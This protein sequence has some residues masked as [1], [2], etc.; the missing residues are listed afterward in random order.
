M[1][2]MRYSRAGLSIST[3]AGPEGC[4][5]RSGGRT[6][7]QIDTMQ[8]GYAATIGLTMDHWIDLVCF[9]RQLDQQNLGIT[10]TPESEV[11]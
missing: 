8:P 2:T 3:Y 5:K 10:T 4:N 1:S 7:I 11:S 6:M 9:I